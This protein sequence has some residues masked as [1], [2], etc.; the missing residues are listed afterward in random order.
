[1][2]S[3]QFLRGI[4]LRFLSNP[5]KLALN[6][7]TYISPFIDCSGRVL[8]V[9]A[10]SGEVAHLVQNVCNVKCVCAD[11]K[12]LRRADINYI[13]FDGV[14]LPF[15]RNSFSTAIC[16]FVLHH[17]FHQKEL[18]KEMMRVTDSKIIILEDLRQNLFDKF[19][20]ILHCITSLF[21]YG[22]FRLKF[23]TNNSWQRC[24]KEL[25]LIL[26]DELKIGRGRE[27]LYPITRRMYVLN[28][29]DSIV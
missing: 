17:C 14:T 18:L 27:Y 25:G 15:K 12:N 19:L 13:L 3:T 10:G 11:I 16:C 28:V 20:V 22:S 29:P 9:G 1:M 2:H 21:N 24:Y 5:R 8:D 4:S 6:T 23:R 7:F 26:K